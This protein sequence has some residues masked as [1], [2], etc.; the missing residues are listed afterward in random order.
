MVLL[1]LSLAQAGAPEPLER[2]AIVAAGSAAGM[3]LS[4][5]AWGATGQVLDN[6]DCPISRCGPGVLTAAGAIGGAIP[7]GIVGAG[8][9]GKGL[10]MRTGRVVLATSGAAVAGLA[11]VVGCGRTDA[12]DEVDALLPVCVGAAGVAMPVAA[13]VVVATDHRP[14]QDLAYD[15]NILPVVGPSSVGLTVAAR[16]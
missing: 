5:A 10:G 2:G 14:L 16:C 4:G 11:L 1:L 7:G 15:V 12:V 13:V 3:V 6:F 8:T 9:A